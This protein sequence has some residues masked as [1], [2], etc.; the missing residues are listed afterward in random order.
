MDP[1]IYTEYRSCLASMGHV[2]SDWG[3]SLKENLC[4]NNS[5]EVLEL[6]KVFVAAFLERKRADAEKMTYLSPGRPGYVEPFHPPVESEEYTHLL[7]ECACTLRTQK[8]AYYDL[9][10]VIDGKEPYARPDNN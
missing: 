4:G 1:T 9:A 5:A 10:V 6:F 7:N 2:E 3:P 8:Q